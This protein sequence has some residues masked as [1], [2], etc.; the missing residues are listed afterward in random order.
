MKKTSVETAVGVFVLIGLIS[1][2][3]LTIKAGQNGVVRRRLLHA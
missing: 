1:V 2:A 3:Y